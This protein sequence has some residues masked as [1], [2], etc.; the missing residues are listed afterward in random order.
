MSIRITHRNIELQDLG[1]IRY[2]EAWDYQTSLFKHSHDLK[3]ANRDLPAELQ[4]ETDHFLLTCEHEPVFTLGKSGKEAHL[5]K[6]KAFLA[7]QGIEMVRTNRGGDI[8]YHG[9]GQLVVYPIL[10]LDHFYTDIHRYMRELEEVVICTLANFDIVAGRFPG[11]TGVWLDPD[12]PVRARKIC[13]QGVKCSRWVTMHGLA[14]NVHTDLAPFR[15]MVPCGIEGKAV[16]S[17]HLESEERPDVALVKS[18]LI[19][20]FE[21]VFDAFI[22]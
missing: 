1:R 22:W 5:L 21:A 19:G 7:Q 18:A 11:Y 20:H 15:Y 8:T 16:T 4:E 2:Q 13:A 3:V 12:D 9:P 14:L 6:S 10:D 17:M